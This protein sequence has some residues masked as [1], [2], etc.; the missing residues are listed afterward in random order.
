M[1]FTVRASSN[2]VIAFFRSR[3]MMKSY[4]KRMVRNHDGYVKN[5]F[6]TIYNRTIYRGLTLK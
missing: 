5:D 6:E 4:Y 3:G 2:Y 1:K